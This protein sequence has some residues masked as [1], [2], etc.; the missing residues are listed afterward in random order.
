MSYGEHI[1]LNLYMKYEENLPSGAPEM[2]P[3]VASC[4]V[5]EW[6]THSVE[7]GAVAVGLITSYPGK[8]C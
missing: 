1:Q 2:D 6:S 5:K 7:A 3:S 8:P 4:G